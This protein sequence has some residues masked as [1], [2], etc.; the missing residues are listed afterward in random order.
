MV[1]FGLCGILAV[2]LFGPFL[3]KKIEEELK[4]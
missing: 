2:G 1:F 3:I 4:V